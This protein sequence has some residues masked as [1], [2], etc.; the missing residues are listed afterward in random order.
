M[1][2]VLTGLAVTWVTLGF[3][4]WGYVLWELLCP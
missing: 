4:A 3:I 2:R 1:K